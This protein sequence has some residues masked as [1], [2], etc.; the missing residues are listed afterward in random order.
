MPYTINRHVHGKTFQTDCSLGKDH[1]V[2]IGKTKCTSWKNV[3][4]LEKLRHANVQTT[5][6]SCSKDPGIKEQIWLVLK[7]L[8]IWFERRLKKI[9]GLVESSRT[10][11]S[12]KCSQKLL[13]ILDQFNLGLNNSSQNDKNNGTT[14]VAQRFTSERHTPRLH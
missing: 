8:T 14:D 11:I 3:L 9:K 7:V 2:C 10:K 13:V 12:W 5:G 1:V 6:R 4:E